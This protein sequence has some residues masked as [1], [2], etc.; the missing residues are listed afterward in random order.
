MCDMKYRQV[1]SPF[2]FTLL[3]SNQMCLTDL[4]QAL[5]LSSVLLPAVHLSSAGDCVALWFAI[6]YENK[7]FPATQKLSVHLQRPGLS[8]SWRRLALLDRDAGGAA[9]VPAAG[10]NLPSLR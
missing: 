8:P 1:Y 6:R 9:S 2:K 10:R 5:E 4:Q 3:F 7:V